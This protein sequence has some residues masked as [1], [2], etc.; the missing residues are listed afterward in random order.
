MD[1]FLE[2]FVISDFLVADADYF[3]YSGWEEVSPSL[4]E[5]LKHGDGFEEGGEVGDFQEYRQLQVTTNS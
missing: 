5:S 4:V 2:K 1:G 3:K